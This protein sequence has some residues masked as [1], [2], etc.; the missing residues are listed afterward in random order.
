VSRALGIIFVPALLVVFGYSVVLH[1]LGVS[2]GYSRL[3]LALALFL[4][5]LWWL[6]RSSGS[7]PPGGSNTRS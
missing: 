6:S 7:R 3:F 4:A 2:P 5:V 1:Y